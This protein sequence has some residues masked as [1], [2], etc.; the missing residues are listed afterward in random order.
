MQIESESI[1]QVLN[2]TNP[3]WRTKQVPE[4][5]LKPMHRLAYHE[6]MSIMLH[7]DI[8]RTVL[9]TGARHIPAFMYLL[10]HAEAQGNSG[11]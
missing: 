3:W 7:P 6:A 5:Y 8:R 10:G 4:V 1:L 11:V 2:S 9:L